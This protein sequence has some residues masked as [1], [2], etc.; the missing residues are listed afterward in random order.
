MTD[1]LTAYG[2][3]LLCALI[4]SISG[5]W[6]YIGTRRSYQNRFSTYLRISRGLDLQA[7]VPTHD[8]GADPLPR[9][10]GLLRVTLS[11]RNH[12]DE[13]SLGNSHE[14]AAEYYRL[15]L[16]EIDTASGL[17]WPRDSE[18]ESVCSNPDGNDNE[19]PGDAAVDHT[20]ASERPQ[21][22]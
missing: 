16:G 14:E 22:E 21:A 12:V 10:I 4:A 20:R 17:D 7:S 15:S 18:V 2:V 9:D 1:L 13:S 8:E 19:T 5:I 6:A 3:A 11:H